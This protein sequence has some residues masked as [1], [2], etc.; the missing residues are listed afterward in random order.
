MGIVCFIIFLSEIK[1]V[2]YQ[3]DLFSLEGK[4]AIVTGAGGVLGGHAAIYLASVGVKVVCVGRTQSSLDK[5]V[6]TIKSNGNE[7]TAMTGDVLDESSLK[8]I[9]K[10][11]LSKYGSIDILIN[12]AGGNMPGAV[13]TP[14][15]SLFDMSIDAFK[16]VVDLNLHGSVLPSL[17]FG[18]YMAEKKEGV[19][20][21]FSS[22][23][24]V[25][26]ITRVAGYSAGKAAIENFTR[27]MA[28]EMA[29]K[30]G[31]GVRVNAIAPG[32][33][34]GDQNR[35]LLTN[36]DGSLTSRGEA[37]VRNTP[38][39]RFGDSDEL[40][41]TLHWMCAPASKFVTGVTVPVDGGFSAYTG[42]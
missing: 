14:D 22:M 25:R 20:I 27:W 4:V 18:K 40:N 23:T 29:Q 34:V 5:T 39:G 12:A 32:F 13:V 9:S 10:N 28:V 11:T 2:T 38:F 24:V 31:E 19:I 17:V 16:E 41:G 15:Q 35:A 37:I 33:F 42:V 36:P 26:S 3:M 7:G 21:N 6:E 8:L 30:V 1:N